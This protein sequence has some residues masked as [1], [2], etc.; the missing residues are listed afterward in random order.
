MA[1]WKK[2]TLTENG[3]VGGSIFDEER[4]WREEDESES[5]LN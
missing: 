5:D 3:H 1:V 4:V 2:K